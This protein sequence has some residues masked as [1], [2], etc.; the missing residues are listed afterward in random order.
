[1]LYIILGLAICFWLSSKKMHKCPVCKLPSAYTV[2]KE[3]VC[4]M[5]LGEERECLNCGHYGYAFEH[6]IEHRKLMG[7]DK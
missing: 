3:K 6:E 1:M 7:I 2:K 4:G 5:L